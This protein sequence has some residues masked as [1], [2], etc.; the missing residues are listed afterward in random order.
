MGRRRVHDPTGVAV[1][2]L[3]ICLG[4]V[5][6]WQTGSM[7]PMGSVFPIT[8]SAAMIVFSVLLIL[9]NLVIGARAAPAEDRPIEEMAGR[10]RSRETMHRVGFIAAMVFWIVALPL[11]GFFVASLAG[12]FLVMA[13]SLH[14][15]LSM[16]QALLLAATGIV[17]VA[18]FYFI[19][20]E[21]LLIPMPSGL[22]F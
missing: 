21:V 18:G 7:T 6:I 10:E 20:R 17:M 5:L 22:F 2:V 19:M 4:I 16:K 13:V 15:R 1:A 11:L 8:V 3:F 9:R 12:F 14:E